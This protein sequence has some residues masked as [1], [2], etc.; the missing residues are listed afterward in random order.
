MSCNMFSVWPMADGRRDSG[1]ITSLSH[2]SDG[3]ESR[4][5]RPMAACQNQVLLTAIAETW[6]KPRRPKPKLGQVVL[7]FCSTG[8]VMEAVAEIRS[9]FSGVSQ[10]A[11]QPS[12]LVFATQAP[13]AVG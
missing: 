9:A 2:I 7:E 4:A 11:V 13:T 8:A 3:T 10:H 1:H 12:M 6:P 5:C